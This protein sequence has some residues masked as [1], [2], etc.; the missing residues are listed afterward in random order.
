[1]SVV[2]SVSLA[3]VGRGDL[4]A[5]CGACAGRFP[6][7]IEMAAPGDG[8]PRPRAIAPLTAAQDAELAAFCPGLGQSAPPAPAPHPLWG[9]FLDMRRA[10]ATDDALRHRAAS[11]G[12]MG[13]RITT[14]VNDT[15]FY[16][17]YF[18]MPALCY[19]PKG[20]NNHGF[21]ER[22]NLDQLK[23]TTLAMACF[24]ADWCG[25]QPLE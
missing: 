5:G 2:N 16:G 4:C 18:D 10:W 11:G 25:L 7:V 23:T 21:D 14:A 8:W 17:L 15:R 12:E 20:E 9:G 3:R 6:K 13:A 1:M 22:T 24:I 19:G